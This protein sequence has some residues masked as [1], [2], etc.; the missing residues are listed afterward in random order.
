[1]SY[2][3]LLA[4]D[5]SIALET[6]KFNLAGLK[7]VELTTANSGVEALKIIK[8]NPTAFAVIVV[9]FNMP[10]RD[11]AT[12]IKEILAINPKSQIFVY[13]GDY[14]REALKRSYDAG[15]SDFLEKEKFVEQFT[16]AW[17]LYLDGHFT[18]AAETFQKVLN[19]NQ[20]TD[21]PSRLYL[22]RC[23]ALHINPPKTWSGVYVATSK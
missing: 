8:A 10:D 13:S 1:M 18:Q 17:Q 4:D 23:K 16:Q 11:G 9:D 14:S 20:Q 7:D 19:Q 21:G 12:L 2:K 15:A 3:V 6:A 22:D 5:E